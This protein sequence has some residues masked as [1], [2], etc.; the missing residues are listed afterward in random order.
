[1]IDY[2]QLDLLY[3]LVEEYSEKTKKHAYVGMKLGA[4]PMSCEFKLTIELNRND[5][6]IY[7]YDCVDDLID[8]I[9]N[10]LKALKLEPKFKLGQEVWFL[11][12]YQE[13]MSF[14]IDKVSFCDRTQEHIY[15][16]N[17]WYTP[18]HMLFESKK[19]LIEAQI[20]KWHQM[21]REEQ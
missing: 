14:V 15:Y 12:A 6:D 9:K 8:L 21:L 10:K 11:D 2:R 1:M 13:V 17:C 16:K 5:E 3:A 20:K 18:E 19:Q 7:I 4:H